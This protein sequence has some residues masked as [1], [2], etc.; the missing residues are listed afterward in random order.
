MRGIQTQ[1]ERSRDYFPLPDQSNEHWQSWSQR[2]EVNTFHR[3]DR[4]CL[5][6]WG[7]GQSDCSLALKCGAA[8]G[9]CMPWLP[10]HR[11]RAEAREHID[12]LLV[13]IGWG[14]GWHPHNPTMPE[15]RQGVSEPGKEPIHLQMAHDQALHPGH[16]QPKYKP[17]KHIWALFH[18]C[19]I[20]CRY[21]HRATNMAHFHPFPFSWMQPSPSPPSPVP[22]ISL[23][24][25]FWDAFQDP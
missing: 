5:P 22:L 21:V 1:E 16:G 17:I 13:F 6:L 20:V 25:W 14:V 10:M 11:K 12:S 8:L 23:S 7:S 18:W 2:G 4:P 24:P 19:S 15:I 9:D 3:T